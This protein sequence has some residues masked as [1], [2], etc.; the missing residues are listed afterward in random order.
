MNALP[1]MTGAITALLFCSPFLNN[2]KCVHSY[3][4]FVEN[5]NNNN[6]NYTL[7]ILI[8]RMILLKS[9]VDFFIY[10]LRVESADCWTRFRLRL[11]PNFWILMIRIMIIDG[12]QS[13]KRYRLRYRL[14]HSV[15][16]PIGRWHPFNASERRLRAARSSL[17][18]HPHR[19]V[20]PLTAISSPSTLHLK[21]HSSSDSSASHFVH[22]SLPS[23]PFLSFVN[24]IRIRHSV[25]FAH[26]FILSHFRIPSTRRTLPRAPVHALETIVRHRFPFVTPLFIHCFLSPVIFHLF[27]SLIPF[28][29]SNLHIE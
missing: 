17:L 19:L 22:S 3:K 16:R 23:R 7:K 11:A 9:L 29:F 28:C 1:W 26:S 6:S 8:T 13:V 2:Q 4:S 25:T 15:P 21:H 18:S 14:C 27:I 10:V 12:K 5:Y 24:S 20:S